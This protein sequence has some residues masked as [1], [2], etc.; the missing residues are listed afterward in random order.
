MSRLETR[1]VQIPEKVKVLLNNKVVEVIGEKGQLVRDFSQVPIEIRVE[2][3]KIIVSALRPRRKESALVGT[4]VSHINNMIKGVTEGF[5]YKLK[6]VYSHFP[7][8]VKVQGNYVTIENFIGE[9]N[10]R[11]ALI[12]GNSTVSVKG[13]DVIVKGINIEDVSQTAANIE[14]ATIVRKR[15]TRKFLDGIY[16]Y[17]KLE[18]MA[19]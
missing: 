8:S 9:R 2:G 7:M 3:N 15:D 19:D 18:G 17:E 13:D 5:T 4:V 16:I 1:M 11:R 10:P 12:M 6:I 14:Q